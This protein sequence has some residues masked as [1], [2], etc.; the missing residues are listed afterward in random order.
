MLYI[1]Q[2]N[3]HQSQLA[4]FNPVLPLCCR[5]NVLYFMIKKH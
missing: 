5:G 3:D 2:H 1:G 4:A